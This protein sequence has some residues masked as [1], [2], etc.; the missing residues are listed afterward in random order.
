MS[1]IPAGFERE[2][3]Q[4]R[5]WVADHAHTRIMSIPVF[6]RAYTYMY[7]SVW[8]CMCLFMPNNSCM[9]L[10]MPYN[11]VHHD[12]NSS[13]SMRRPAAA[14][15]MTSVPSNLNHSSRTIR[16]HWLEYPL[17]ASCIIIHRYYYQL[18]TCVCVVYMQNR[19]I[20]Y[21][22][23]MRAS[24]WIHF[25]KVQVGES[26]IYDVVCYSFWLHLIHVRI[27]L[28]QTLFINFWDPT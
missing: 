16:R 18:V 13:S 17:V 14:A 23:Y 12:Y 19:C 3:K 26:N 21:S 5:S 10:F 9:C 22:S 28:I 15:G 20:L 27:S 2:Y 24:Q 11:T 7:V 25:I 8:T 1:C 4:Q 6:G